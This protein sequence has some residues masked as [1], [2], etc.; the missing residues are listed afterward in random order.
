MVANINVDV[1]CLTPTW[2]NFE[3]NRYR[4]YVNDDLITERNWSWD[5][6]TY[7]HEDIWVDVAT[8]TA[9][10]IRLEPVLQEQSSAQFALRNLKV[11]N[12]ELS[13]VDGYRIQLS[14]TL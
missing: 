12:R 9:H 6:N 4:I 7:I 5:L 10:I 13:D 1:H 11:N 14:F 8:Q 2:V 3:N